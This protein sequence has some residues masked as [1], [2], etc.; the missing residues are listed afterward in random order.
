MTDSHRRGNASELSTNAIVP[1]HALPKA[2][3]K[4]CSVMNQAKITGVEKEE[5]QYEGDDK[6]SSGE[7]SS[8]KEISG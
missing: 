1:D 6:L 8:G 5:E 4:K 3:S 7:L 2:D